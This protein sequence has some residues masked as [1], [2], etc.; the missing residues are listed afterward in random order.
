VSAE[1]DKWWFPGLPSTMHAR[2]M[3]SLFLQHVLH[4][5]QRSTQVLCTKNYSHH[6]GERNEGEEETL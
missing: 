3:G 2:R 5:V 4:H 1:V 6:A